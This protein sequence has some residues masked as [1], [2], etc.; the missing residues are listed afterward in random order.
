VAYGDYSTSLGVLSEADG[1]YAVASGYR[2]AANGDYTLAMG[3]FATADGSDA[4]ALGTESEAAGTSSVALGYG[5]DAQGA[6]SVALGSGSV[7]DRDNTISV[8]LAGGER[9][10]TNVAAGTQ[11]TDAVNLAQ[12]KQVTDNVG[13][14]ADSA[15]TYDDDRSALPAPMA[16]RW[17][18][19]PAV[20]SLPAA[21]R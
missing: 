11:D 1:A 10:I 13:A 18:T 7:A 20:R 14:V 17:I 4:L 19:W 3:W 9:Q 2:S 5:S 21:C 8:G 6:N 12:L 15:V 16:R